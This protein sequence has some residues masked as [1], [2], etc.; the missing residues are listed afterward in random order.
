MELRPTIVDLAPRDIVARS[1][2]LEVLE[3]RGARPLA[4]Y[5][6]STSATWARS[7][8]RRAPDITEFARTLPAGSGHQPVPSTRRATT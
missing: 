8:R 6:L 5:G 1:M 3:R 4:D 7:A 2:V